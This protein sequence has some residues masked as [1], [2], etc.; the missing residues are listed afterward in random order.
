MK[1]NRLCLIAGLFA[2]ILGVLLF[3]FSHSYSMYTNKDEFLD[4][5]MAID[6]EQENSSE[7]YFQLRAEYLTP[8]IVLENYSMTS[9]ILGLI[10]TF[11]SVIGVNNIKT[12]KS[13]IGLVFLGLSAVLFTSI[14]DVVGLLLESFRDSSPP[15]AD[16]FGI[17]LMDVPIFFI[18]FLLWFIINL[19]GMRNNFKTDINIFPLKCR[20]LNWWYLILIIFTSLLTVYIIALGFFI[21]IIPCLIW[22]YFYFSLMTGIRKSKLKEK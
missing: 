16:S 6:I 15:W 7:Q 5:V 14:A 1:I 19:I 21:L 13:K 11:V 2:L 8:K 3:V 12:P 22:I 9:I 17:P 10:I 18:L 4:K 20:D